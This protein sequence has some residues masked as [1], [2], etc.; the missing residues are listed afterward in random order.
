M[1]TGKLELLNY[2]NFVGAEHFEPDTIVVLEGNKEVRIS[3]LNA[4]DEVNLVAIYT[5]YGYAID[6]RGGFPKATAEA[7]RAKAALA[8]AKARKTMEKVG[9]EIENLP[10]PEP[11]P[12]PVKAVSL[13][14]ALETA[15]EVSRTPKEASEAKDMREYTVVGGVEEVP[16]TRY[17]QTIER[18]VKVEFPDVN[19]KLLGILEGLLGRQVEITIKVVGDAPRSRDNDDEDDSDDDDD[20]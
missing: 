17:V 15:L 16:V 13:E 4:N 3:S 2:K 12:A 20:E 5:V 10:I 7:E 8:S 19:H 14:E 11:A 18:E 1:K 9:L 6:C